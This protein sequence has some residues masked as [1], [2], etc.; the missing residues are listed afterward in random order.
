MD[1]KSLVFCKNAIGRVVFMHY[2]RE[3]MQSQ[4]EL[5]TAA[6]QKEVPTNATY[7]MKA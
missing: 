4:T 1:S 2:S 5:D 3:D 7:V 6:S